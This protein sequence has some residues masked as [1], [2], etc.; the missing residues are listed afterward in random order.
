[1]MAN[2]QKVEAD[3]NINQKGFGIVEILVVIVVVGLIGAVGWLVYDRQK[4]TKQGTTA[5]QSATNQDKTSTDKNQT[6]QIN[7]LTLEDFKV[8]IPLNDKTNKLK[9]GQ[10]TSSAYSDGDKSVAI[11]APELDN[12]W[13]CAAGA[14]GPKGTIGTISITTQSKRSGPYEPL[15]TKKVGAYTYGFEAGDSNCTDSSSFKELETSFKTQFDQ[16]QAY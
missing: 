15:A 7:Y 5:Q 16:L 6:A 8:R 4:T 2:S 12:V 3:T 14:E 10:V 9:L 1:M 13:K 11:L